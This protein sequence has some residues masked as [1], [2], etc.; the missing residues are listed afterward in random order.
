MVG[1]KTRT[2]EDDGPDFSDRK[3][4]LPSSV[5]TCQAKYLCLIKFGH[6]SR[7]CVGK[8]IAMLEMSKILP[9]IIRRF[10]FEWASRAQSWTT[11]AGWF[12]KQSNIELIFRAR[13]TFE[14]SLMSSE[15]GMLRNFAT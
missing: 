3:Y 10:D 14:G 7:S 6:G 15:D 5:L 12:W 1:G 2:L 11:V 4:L 9:E 8:N 13:P